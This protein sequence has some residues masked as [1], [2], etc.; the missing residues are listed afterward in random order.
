MNELSSII[1]QSS[2]QSKAEKK[3]K[4]EDSQF[5]IPETKISAH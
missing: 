4:E 5:R 3:S 2:N 1:K